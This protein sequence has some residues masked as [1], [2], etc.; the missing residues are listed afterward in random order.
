MVHITDILCG[1]PVNSDQLS[2]SF[3]CLVAPGGYVIAAKGKHKKN[4]LLGNRVRQEIIEDYK[5]SNH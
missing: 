2:A 1:S 4:W 5:T 3:A